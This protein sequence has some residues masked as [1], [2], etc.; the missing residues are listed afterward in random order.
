MGLLTMLLLG[1]VIC[2]YS[3]PQL[4]LPQ[5]ES[6]QHTLPGHIIFKIRADIDLH[7][8]QRDKPAELLEKLQVD[9]SIA[10]VTRVFP[11]HQKPEETYGKSGF[12]QTDLSRIYEVVLS[13]PELTADLMKELA[14]SGLVEYVQPRFIPESLIMYDL[15]SNGIFI[16]NDSLVSYQYYLKTIWA[17]EA[18]A[19]SKGDTSVV[20]GIVDTGTDLHHPD[21]IDAIAYN[22]NDPVNGEDSDGDGYVDNFY[23]WDLGEE[24][25]DPGFNKSAHGLHVSGIA[26]ASSNNREG[27]AATGF[28]SRFLP[29]KVDDEFGRLVKAYEGIV[30]AADQGASV[31]NCSWGSHLHPGPFGQDI[32]NYA[33][34]NRDA[35]VVAAAGNAS[36]NRP[37]YPAALEHTLSVAATDSLDVKAGFSSYGHFVDLVAP[38]LGILSTW[39][40]GSYMRSGGTSMAAPIV[41]GAAAI[42]RSYYPELNAIE[43]AAL[44]KTTTDP[45]DL[46]AGNQAY[47]RQLGFGRLN[48]FRALSE[49]MHSYVRIENHRQDEDQLAAIRTGQTFSLSM[50][51]LCELAPADMLKA[52]LSVDSEYVS[53]ETDTLSFVFA[54]PLYSFDNHTAP[55][56]LKALPGIP[57][58]HRVLFTVSFLDEKGS[59]TGRQSFVRVLNAQYL[60]IRAG[61]LLTTIS[62]T[63]AIGYN[64]PRYD[65]GMGF[66]FQ[67]SYTLLKAGGLLIGSDQFH[68]SDQIYGETEGSFSAVFQVNSIPE[69]HKGSAAGHYYVDGSVSDNKTGYEIG[70]FYRHHYWDGDEAEDFLILDYDLVNLSGKQRS[71]LYTGFFADWVLRDNKYHRASFIPSFRMGYAWDDSGGHYTGIQLLSPGGVRH[72]AFDNTGLGGSIKITDGFGHFQKYTALTSNRIVAGKYEA[73]NDISTLVSTGPF[74]LDHGDSLHIAFALHAAASYEDLL[75]NAQRAAMRYDQLRGTP[76]HAAW[77]GKYKNRE[78]IRA[79]PNPFSQRLHVEF[80]ASLQGTFTLQLIDVTGRVYIS[81]SILLR[82]DGIDQLILDTSGMPGGMYVLQLAG[83]GNI[84]SVKLICHP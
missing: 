16:P 74:V 84:F 70:L 40:N 14:A 17:F 60:H 24:N 34:F 42:I 11:F 2:A 37:F 39:V 27:I 33:V 15:F 30:Y 26:A 78:P 62:S 82:Q 76:T 67:N 64:Y 12:R 6:L 63:G 68:I 31:I 47:S 58:N 36:D 21:L 59:L 77:P 79:M 81:R 53:V 56:V 80:S 1:L 35:L 25:N 48:L 49:P 13:D 72:Y 46:L 50:D 69:R 57:E 52:V 71:E 83:E 66:L 22:Y 32:I 4:V 65:Q 75:Q 23:G 20:I 10:R 19:I 3:Q 43:V 8:S 38:G 55:F 44:I 29:V 61:D 18:W 73:V 9:K 51:F 54:E 5:Q 41:S 45:V 28:Y 7:G